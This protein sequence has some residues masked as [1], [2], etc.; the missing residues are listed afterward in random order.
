MPLM[1][2]WNTVVAS[3][4][5]LATALPMSLILEVICPAM[6]FTRFLIPSTEN[7]LPRP[8]LIASHRWL[9]ISGKFPMT[10]LALCTKSSM[11]SRSFSLN[12]STCP[13]RG[14]MAKETRSPM[15]CLMSL[16]LFLMFWMCWLLSASA[17]LRLS[18][19]YLSMIAW[20]AAPFFSSSL[21]SSPVSIPIFFRDA[22]VPL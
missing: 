10:T 15:L 1:A 14:V 11:P 4:L 16:K 21:V 5:I 13:I 9:M 17:M 22:S 2:S 18:S 12:A 8:D 3:V 20:T 6:L 19:P 7:S